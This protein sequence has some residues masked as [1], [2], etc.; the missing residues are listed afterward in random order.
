RA[1]V[2][3]VF[4]LGGGCHH[5]SAVGL[6]RVVTGGA[7]PFLRVVAVDVT[8]HTPAHV[9]RRVL[10]DAIHRLDRTMTCLARD[11]GIDV[12]EVRE[13]HVLRHFVDAYPRHRLA[14]WLPELVVVRELLDL[15]TVAAHD[16]VAA[17]ARLHRG[18]TGIR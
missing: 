2:S 10:I 11:T 1:I 16:E 6:R 15:G 7:P 18:H 8:L 5:L 3:R 14:A 13:A 12:A 17:H 9:Q 4:A